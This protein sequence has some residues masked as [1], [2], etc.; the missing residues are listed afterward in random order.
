[1]NGLRKCGM[2]FIPNGILLSHEEKW[3]AFIHK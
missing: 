1:M 3:N 2:V